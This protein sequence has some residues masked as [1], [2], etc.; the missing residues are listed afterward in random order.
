MHFIILK[1]RFVL[2]F[3]LSPLGFFRAILRKKMM[4]IIIV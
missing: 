1:D 3:F 2:F 4:M